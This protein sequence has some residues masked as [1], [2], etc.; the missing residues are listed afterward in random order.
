MASEIK[1]DNISEKTTNNG[2]SLGSSIKFKQYTT[3]QREALTPS[4][5]DM[6]YD[7]DLNSNFLYNGT[8]WLVITT[9]IPQ[10]NADFLL[11]A[12]GG[13]GGGSSGDGVAGGGGA[14][15]GGMLEGS[16]YPLNTGTSYNC[17]VGAGGTAG[18]QGGNGG[19]GGDTSFNGFIAD[20]GGAG[21]DADDANTTISSGGSAGGASGSSGAGAGTATQT[22]RTVGLYTWSGFGNAGGTKNDGNAGSFAGGGGG[23]A[24]GAAS[25]RTRGVGRANSISGSSVTYAEGG[26]GQGTSNFINAGVSG[27]TNRGNGGNGANN[28]ANSGGAGGSGVIIIS[29]PSEYTIQYTGVVGTTITSGSTKITTITSGSGSIAFV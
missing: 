3:A 10:F 15:A 6:V 4:E 21:R 9:Q 17:A 22:N 11:V 27:T 24:G 23:G 1:V 16:T 29:Y 26:Y 12:G 13:G 19:K 28:G 25:G 5:G 2:I 18:S 14:G 8:S 7:T 20:G